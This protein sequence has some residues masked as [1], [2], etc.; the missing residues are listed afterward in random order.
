MF[1]TVGIG[2]VVRGQWYYPRTMRRIQ[3]RIAE[4][5]RATDKMDAL[6]QSRSYRL[7]TR[8]MTGVGIFAIA[9]GI[10]FRLAE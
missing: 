10:V 5:G 9:A 7:V 6:L 8:T 1:I 4:R 2:A 3:V